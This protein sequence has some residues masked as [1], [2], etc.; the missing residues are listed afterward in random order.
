MQTLSLELIAD[1]SFTHFFYLRSAMCRAV[2]DISSIQDDS[3]VLLE[4][5]TSSLSLA[6]SPSEVVS[7]DGKAVCA[8]ALSKI[9]YLALKGH[10]QGS[11]TTAQTISDLISS[12]VVQSLPASNN[13]LSTARRS[14][15]ASAP[16]FE[17][18]VAS[19]VSYRHLTT[20]NKMKCSVK[21]LT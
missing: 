19:S 15:F 2:V 11:I 13:S 5:L 10:L 18:P 17:Y 6:F 8:T 1:N 7:E 20:Y 14:S 16:I 3:T 9:A 12:F 21:T 4:S